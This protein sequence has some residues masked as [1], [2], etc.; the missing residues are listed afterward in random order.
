MNKK[1]LKGGIKKGTKKI[2][3]QIKEYGNINERKNKLIGNIK[4]KLK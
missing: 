4:E 1:G 2:K 3:K